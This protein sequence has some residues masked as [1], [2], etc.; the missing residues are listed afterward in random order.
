MIEWLLSCSIFGGLSQ[1][2]VVNLVVLAA[3]TVV[4]FVPVILIGSGSNLPLE[5]TGPLMPAADDG[6]WHT[7][8]DDSKKAVVFSAMPRE[9]LIAC[10]AM[11]VAPTMDVV[12]DLIRYATNAHHANDILTTSRSVLRMNL[13]ER[14]MFSLGCVVCGVTT[15]CPLAT[16]YKVLNILNLA[17]V[18][19]SGFLTI[20]P[21]VL[22]LQRAGV[23]GAG[24]LATSTIVAVCV[25]CLC[26]SF[27]GLV[28]NPNSSLYNGMT[29]TGVVVY[30]VITVVY[31]V[32]YARLAVPV[33]QRLS[34][35]LGEEAPTTAAHLRAVLRACLAHTSK[36]FAISYHAL[37]LSIIFITNIWYE[38]DLRKQ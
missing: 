12:I 22:F 37:S 32:Q 29:L 5:L 7:I 16:H 33:I 10:L 1:I 20:G 35:G 25:A 28:Q 11:A 6:F 15:L 38:G 36:N 19:A 27:Q 34:D 18:N 8:T 4:C 23:L 26:A 24:S 30:S 21:V 13:I 17:T 2:Y 9:S 31:V 3:S 14:A